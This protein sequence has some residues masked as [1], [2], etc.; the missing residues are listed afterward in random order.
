MAVVTMLFG[1]SRL[2]SGEPPPDA[3]VSNVVEV[4]SSLCVSSVLFVTIAEFVTTAPAEAVTVYVIVNVASLPGG[5]LAID[6]AVVGS[7]ESCVNI[8]PESWL[9][10]K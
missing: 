7:V 2:H 10:E 6:Q 3:T 4:L 5:R 9:D 1:Q 8:G